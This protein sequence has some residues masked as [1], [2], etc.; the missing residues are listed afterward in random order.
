MTETSLDNL[1]SAWFAPTYKDLAEIWRDFKTAYGDAGK[2]SEQEKRIELIGGGAID[3]W[4]MED[5]DSGRGRRYGRVVVDEAAKASHLEHA[6]TQTIRP[7]LTDFKGDAWFLS[8]PQGRDYFWK[9]YCKGLDPHQTQ[10]AAWQMPTLANPYID[11]AEVREAQE[12]LP[13]RAFKQEYLAEFLE[14]GGAVFRFIGEA[15]G[16]ERQERAAQYHSYVIGCDWAQV[17]DFSVFTVID[18]TLGHVVY[19]DRSNHVDYLLQ[20]DRLRALCER[21][22][23]DIVVSEKTGNLALSDFLRRATYKAKVTDGN[24]GQVSEKIVTLPVHDFNTTN[25]TKAEVVQ[26]LALAFERREIRIPDDSV[27]I[28]ELEAFTSERLPSGKIRYTAPEGLHDDCVMSLALCWW[29]ARRIARAERLT[30]IAIASQK[31][32]TA[33]YAPV[34]QP[35]ASP[36]HEMT[37]N[38]RMQQ[39]LKEESRPRFYGFGAEEQEDEEYARGF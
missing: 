33:G 26:A 29:R 24:T 8:T 14:D 35:Q 38:M 30:P 10:F 1:P 17:D 7:T 39:W 6:W 32:I 3:F 12:T 2:P 23:P 36:Y 13:E 22:Q 20:I 27:L 15:K 28:G 9:L 16:A 19:V 21:F 11:P 18:A 31:A 4:S 25:E 34:G 5:P 37:L